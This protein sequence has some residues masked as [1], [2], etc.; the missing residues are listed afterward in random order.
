MDD[1]RPRKY[2]TW[3]IMFPVLQPVLYS[4]LDVPN[5]WPPLKQKHLEKGNRRGELAIRHTT[6]LVAYDGD[7]IITL[8]S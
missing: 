6:M 7:S 8:Q 2:L 5:N 3:Y 1:A 4:Y